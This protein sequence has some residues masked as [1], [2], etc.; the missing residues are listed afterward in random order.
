MI[1]TLKNTS[2]YL[3]VLCGIIHIFIAFNSIHV[4]IESR[5]HMIQE[6]NSQDI[7][8]WYSRNYTIL[9]TNNWLKGWTWK[10]VCFISRNGISIHDV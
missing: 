4:S 8:K 9:G 10:C 5:L 2:S 1:Y 6:H 3:L 7:K